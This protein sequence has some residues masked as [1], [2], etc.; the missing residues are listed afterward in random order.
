MRKLVLQTVL[1][2]FLGLGLI[3]QPLSAAKSAILYKD[4]VAVIIYHHIDDD[5]KSGG[6]ITAQLLKDQLTYL[7]SKGY[8]FITLKQFKAYMEG[9]PV[10]NNAVLV[11]FDDGYESFYVNAYP[12][13][14]QMRVPAV[15]F[16]ITGDLENPLASYIPSMSRDDIMEMTSDTNFTDFQCHSH[17][18]HYKL[19]TGGA[20]LVS[21]LVKDG[22]KETEEQYKQRVVGDTK[23]CVGALSELYTEPVDSYAYPFGIYDKPAME[24]IR[25]GGIKYAF[26]VVP[27]VA[28][29]EVDRMQIPRIDAG[30]SGVSPER[31]HQAI[32]RRVVAPMPPTSEVPLAET[33]SAFGGKV[34]QSRDGTVQIGFGTHTWSGAAG[35]TKLTAPDG[36]TLALHKPLTWK[37]NKIFITLKDLEQAIGGQIVYN[38]NVQSFALRQTIDTKP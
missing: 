27:E 24:H 17:H 38:P 19:P 8:Q 33:V 22:V 25:Q 11:T 20:A 10:P 1:L 14:K 30:N 23:A 37:N 34:A 18:F 21:R 3:F 16:V 35:G 29:R 32:Q 2:A 31:L 26:T 4:Q 13:L 6:T 28:T 15:N 5:A 12:L 7:K 9:A 36:R